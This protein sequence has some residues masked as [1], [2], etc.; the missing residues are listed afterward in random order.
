M[1]DRDKPHAGQ[2]TKFNDEAA[3]QAIFLAKKGFIDVDIAEA[4]GITQ[5]TLCNWKNAHPKFF[6]ALKLAKIESDSKVELSLYERACGYSHPED[7]IFNNNGEILTAPTTK[8]YPPD[9]VSMIFWLKN[10][11]PEKWKDKQE[12]AHTGADGKPLTVIVHRGSDLA[13]IPVEEQE[14]IQDAEEV[15]DESA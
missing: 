14:Q 12:V 2:P 10:R 5:Q 4:L 13:R 11:Q 7:K 9:P 6:E 15:E 8:H 1:K 3:R